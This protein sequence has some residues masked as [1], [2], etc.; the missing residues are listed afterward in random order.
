MQDYRTG[1]ILSYFVNYGMNFHNGLGALQ[2]RIP[3]ALQMIPGVLLLVGILFQNES[4]R[5]LVEKNRIDDAHRALATVRS[6][7]EDDLRVIKELDEIVEDFQGQEKLS[8]LQQL[9]A[10]CQSKQTFYQCSMAVTLMFWQQW[11]GTNSINYYPPQIFAAI[12]LSATSAGLLATGIYGVVKVCFTALGLM[13]ATEQIG[14]KWSLIIGAAGQAFAMFYI[15]IQSAVSPAV[16]G[17]SLTGSST[18][19]IIR[20]YLFV[21]FYSFGWS[22]DHH[23]S[24]WKVLLT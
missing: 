18:F 8:L 10:A 20:V 2:W 16:R 4:P 13:F 12:G 24:P 17:A 6:K 3:F 15:G 1:I 19:S 9:R 5:W 11:T 21:V 23:P 22:E 14:R 7:L